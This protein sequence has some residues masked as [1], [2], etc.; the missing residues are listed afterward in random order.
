MKEL[1][2]IY[3]PSAAGKSTIEEYIFSN[4]DN[5]EPIISV[6]TRDKRDYEI[7]NQHYYFR[8]VD[9]VNN[10]PDIIASIQIGDNKNWVYAIPKQEFSRIH[11][12]GIFS[13][14]SLQYVLDIAKYAKS[15][16]VKVNIIYIDVPQDIRIERLK[17]RGESKE[18]IEARI[19]FE[20]K[21]SLDYLKKTIEDL[22][23]ING[24]QP[25]EIVKK[26]FE[27][28]FRSLS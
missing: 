11:N 20:D 3:A 26:E 8:N 27:K 19:S 4:I 10:N 14:I 13:A 22:F 2:L 18:S 1:F 21:F 25:I 17:N 6:T 12:Y 24:N 7:E 28:Y 23:I 5:V 16:G 9:F 15:I